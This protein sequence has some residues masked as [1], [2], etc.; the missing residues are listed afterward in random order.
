MEGAHNGFFLSG[1]PEGFNV[2]IG[3]ILVFYRG[4]LYRLIHRPASG[5]I[6]DQRRRLRMALDVVC[7]CYQLS[8]LFTIW[9]LIVYCC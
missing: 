6:M 5:E 9:L 7:I 8:L 2:L 4:S 3:P 1:I